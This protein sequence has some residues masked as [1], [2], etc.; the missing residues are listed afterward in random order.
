M[1]KLDLNNQSLDQLGIAL[2]ES[3]SALTQ[4]SPGG[5]KIED[6]SRFIWD[7]KTQS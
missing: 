7:V 2:E 1:E 5:N 4:G 6:T 3:A